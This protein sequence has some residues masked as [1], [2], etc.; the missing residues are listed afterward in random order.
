MRVVTLLLALVSSLAFADRVSDAR[1][2]RTHDLEALVQKAGLTLPL[3]EVYLRVFK[4]ERQVELWA[5]SKRN[6]PMVLVKTY[7]ICSASGEAGPKRKEGDLQVPEGFY[8]V[9]EFN[10]VSN[11][12]LALKVSYPNASDR[13]RSDHATPGGLIYLHGNCV[14]IGC[15]AIRDEPVEEVYLLAFDAKKKPVRLD[16]FPMRLKAAELEKSDSPHAAFWKE[17]LPG[18]EVFERTHRPPA[19]TV[20]RKTGAYVF[21]NVGK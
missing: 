21:E 15:I 10:A 11:Y 16:S 19:F 3:D 1:K 13:V 4:Q 17:L 6:G 14:S 5:T 12:H 18:L 20:D 9:P 2:R 8:E 7:E